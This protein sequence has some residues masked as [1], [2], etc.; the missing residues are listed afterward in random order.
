[1]AT[2]NSGPIKAA[3]TS[4][5][6]IFCYSTVH[7]KTDDFT[8]FQS[9]RAFETAKEKLYPIQAQGLRNHAAFFA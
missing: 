3:A 8:G 5:L 7:Y 4:S 2:E 6:F 9:P 1:M